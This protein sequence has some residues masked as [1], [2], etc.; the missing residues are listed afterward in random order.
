MDF[1]L[2]LDKKFLHEDLEKIREGRKQLCKTV[3][4]Q[5]QSAQGGAGEEAQRAHIQVAGT[6]GKENIII[7]E[8]VGSNLWME[9]F[10]TEKSEKIIPFSQDREELRYKD[11][12]HCCLLELSALQSTLGKLRSYVKKPK[13]EQKKLQS[14]KTY[15][16]GFLAGVFVASEMVRNEFLERIVLADGL[17]NYTWEKALLLYRNWETVAKRLYCIEGGKSEMIPVIRVNDMAAM[18][19]VRLRGEDM[20]NIWGCYQELLRCL[21]IC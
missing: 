8:A 2:R 9:G 6:G 15:R 11:N 16:Q 17:R 3:L 18:G 5:S 21:K 10:Q 14:D 19:A 4:G 12:D 7:L 13:S 20:K 1:L